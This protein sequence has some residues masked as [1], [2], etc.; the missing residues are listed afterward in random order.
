MDAEDIIWLVGPSCS[1][2][3]KILLL[4]IH[5]DKNITYIQTAYMSNLVENVFVAES[6]KLRFVGRTLFGRPQ[7]V[8][9]FPF[10]ANTQSHSTHLVNDAK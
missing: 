7:R 3:P 6:D 4:N 8:Q 2:T 10:F 1:A 9:Q 5:N